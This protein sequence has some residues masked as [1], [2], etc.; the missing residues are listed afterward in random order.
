MK[1]EDEILQQA[2]CTGI[3]GQR[4]WRVICLMQKLKTRT[5]PTAHSH[6]QWFIVNDVQ[7]L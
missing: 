7:V 6:F 1:V 5:P 2:E 3:Q 4:V